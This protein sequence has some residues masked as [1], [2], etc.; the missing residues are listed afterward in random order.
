MRLVSF[1]VAA[2]AY[3]RFMGRYADE[4]GGRT[5]ES[6]LAGARDGDL[7]ALM[8]VAG[9]RDVRGGEITVVQPYTDF[10]DWWQ[11]YELGVGP[12]GQCLGTV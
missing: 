6:H 7:V 3:Q 4:L 5:D 11:P 10:A 8:R 1:D 9:L 12:A 2:E